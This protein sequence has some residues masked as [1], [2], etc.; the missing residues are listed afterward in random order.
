MQGILLRGRLLGAADLW[1]AA[2]E[3]MANLVAAD[4]LGGCVAARLELALASGLAEAA[5]RWRLASYR[6]RRELR[7]SGGLCGPFCRAELGRTEID[8]C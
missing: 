7:I 3:Q 5:S 8:T 2:D 6:A 1:G 4:Q